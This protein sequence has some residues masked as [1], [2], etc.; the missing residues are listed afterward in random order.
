M[1]IKSA[2]LII[3]L[4]VNSIA[5]A[6][7]TR[8]NNKTEKKKNKR[9][10]IGLVLS[11]G[12]AKGFAHIGVIKV[13]E[14]AG[15]KPDIVTGTS[16][17]SIIGAL[18]AIGY[19]TKDLEKVARTVDWGT[20]LSNAVPLSD[21][22]QEEKNYYSRY[23]LELSV[24]KKKVSLPG[25]L[26][27]GQN[28]QSLLSYLT[29]NIHHESDFSRFPIPYAC[30]ATDIVHGIPVTLNHG[31]LSLAIRASM[32]IP[33]IFTPVEID[34]K[35][36]IDGGWVRNLPVQEAI[37][38]GADIIIAV[39]VGSSLKKREDL[40]DLL[41]IMDQTSWILSTRDTKKQRKL[42]NYIVD[43][44]TKGIASFDFDQADVIIERGYVA[45][46]KQINEFKKL[47]KRVYPTGSFN[48]KIEIPRF[49]NSYMFDKIVIEGTKH[50]S[51]QF[52][53]GLL[54]IKPGD[55]VTL[56]YIKDRIAVVYGSS[57][58]RKVTY[59]LKSYPDGRQQLYVKVKEKP[60]AKLK[61]GIYFDT[62]SSGGVT[63]NLT[64]RNLAF[65]NS[66]LILDT[67]IAKD[68]QG[69]FNYLKYIDRNQHFYLFGGAE[70]AKDSKFR[71]HNIN[72]ED[73]TYVYRMFS[74]DFGMAINFN[75]NITLGSAIRYRNAWAIPD[76]NADDVIDKLRDQDF[77]VNMFFLINTLNRAYY[78]TDGWRYGLDV[79]YRINPMQ[80]V[81]LKDAYKD[82]QKAV[83]D[84]IKLDPYWIFKTWLEKYF[85]VTKK[86]SVYTSATLYLASHNNIGFNDSQFIGGMV[87]FFS[88][89]VQFAGSEKSKYI[90]DHVGKIA[91]GVQFMIFKDL[92]IKFMANYFNVN[93]PAVWLNP[94][95]SKD[96]FEVNGHKMD[97]NFG[98]SAEISYD[99]VIG[100]VRFIIHKDVYNKKPMFFIGIGYPFRNIFPAF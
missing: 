84:N 5:F 90:F 95:L 86:A 57:Y 62:E 72:E 77:P 93:Y 7:Q 33:S 34:G 73:A 100:P 85:E 82:D 61:F 58:Y 37:D 47:A 11:G 66:R 99:S 97:S 79:S 53:K 27:E 13:L 96:S 67:F 30:V 41:A 2:L 19:S 49:Y 15:I 81:T 16:M 48:D 4:L 21:I 38:M 14:E 80:S 32:A 17:G 52:V 69:K 20:A 91:L 75:Q 31:N 43:P 10:K 12:G 42:S 94:T 25:G 8:S 40:N 78:P 87:P 9:P 46:K 76:V 3:I 74:T 70:Y 29:R 63:A 55:H 50:T 60:L 83:D 64:L 51:K 44:D 68:M 35:L 36:L 39:D 26:I 54:R 24:S 98:G 65:K 89:S 23:V 92:Y 88:N 22:A 1:N 18:Y 28:L 71:T 6:G 45:A 59:S 56:D